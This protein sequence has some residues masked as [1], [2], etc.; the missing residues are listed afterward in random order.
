MYTV[1]LQKP[2]QFSRS[3]SFDIAYFQHFSFRID[4]SDERDARFEM[5]DFEIGQR[6]EE[7]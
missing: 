1:P 2:V 6:R 7:R 3:Q 5:Q 4:V